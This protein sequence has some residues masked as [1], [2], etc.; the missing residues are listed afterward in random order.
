MKRSLSELQSSSE[1]SHRIDD[2][3]DSLSVGGRWQC[4]WGLGVATS[5]E[6]VITM[7][8]KTLL[9]SGNVGY[10]GI[11]LLP[12]GRFRSRSRPSRDVSCNISANIVTEMNP[13]H[14]TPTN[15]VHNTSIQL[16]LQSAN[17]APDSERRA[18]WHHFP[19]DATPDA[20]PAAS[21]VAASPSPMQNDPHQWA[22]RA[23]SLRWM[24]C[25]QEKQGHVC[26][27]VLY[28]YNCYH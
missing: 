20:L 27:G 14:T 25:L 2:I 13:R 9:L 17:R 12:V 22:Y 4:R 24:P 26:C 21:G 18:T 7:V 19:T 6:P 8:D 11:G 10:S 28:V 3:S 16:V 15:H 23:S 1:L 5:L